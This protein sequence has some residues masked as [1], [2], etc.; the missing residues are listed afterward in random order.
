MEQFHAMREQ[1]RSRVRHFKGMF[2]DR[3]REEQL[4]SIEEARQEE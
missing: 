3:A 2:A 1:Q 4:Q